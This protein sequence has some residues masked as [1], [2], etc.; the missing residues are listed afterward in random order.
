MSSAGIGS[1]L[2]VNGIIAKLMSIERQPI[3]QIDNKTTAVQ[4]ELT[5]YGTLKGSLSSFQ[6]AVQSLTSTSTY[7]ATKATV[8]DTAQFS[9]TS[10]STAAPGNYSV[11]VVK[12]AKAEKLQSAG[13][14]SSTASIGTGTL[15]FEFGTYSTS[16]A[17]TSFATNTDKKTVSVTIPTGSD[18]LNSIAEAIN[19]AKTGVS[20]TVLNDGTHSYLS[21]SPLDPGAANS[22][23]IT[24]SDDD[25]INS[26]STGLSKLAFDK[27]T[28]YLAGSV[29]F[30]APN[31]VTI[32]ATNNKFDLALDGGTA[33]TVTIPSGNYDAVNIVSVAQTAVDTALGAGKATVSLNGSNQLVVA[34]N[35]VPSTS[36]SAV[37]GNTGYA[38]LIGVDLS[39]PVT[40]TSSNNQ[41]KLA[42]DGGTPTTVTIPDGTYLNDAA[43]IS[44]V[45]TAV[46]TALGGAGKAT[47][48]LDGSNNL[49]IT[50]NTAAS[51]SISATTGNTGSTTLF[52]VSLAAPNAVTISSANNQ[53]MLAVDGGT[54]TAV[55]IPDGSYDA[56]NIVSAFQTAINTAV[57][58]G[59]ATVSLN[60]SNQLVINS[61]ATSGLASIALTEVSG[62]AGLSTL[63]GSS[64]LSGSGA[65]QMTE[66]VAPQDAELII[67][68]VTVKKSTNTLTDA[69]RGVTLILTKES[70]TA[71]TVTV[72]NDNSALSTA[73]DTLVKAY[74]TT[75]GMLKD[76]LSYDPTTGKA[77]ALQSEGAVRLIQSQLRTTLQ[78]LT[79]GTGLKGLSDIGVSFQRDGSLAFNSDKLKTA[80]SDPTKN[81]KALFI[82]ENSSTDGIANKLNNLLDSFLQGN[83]TLV[84]RTDGLNLEMVRYARRKSEL[85]IRMTA[86]ETRYRKQYSNL[87]TLVASMSK[88]SA[89]LSQQLANLPTVNSSK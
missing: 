32:N 1:G 28:G 29:G 18:S 86:I 24:V 45:Q 25:G 41:F 88:T 64:G 78:A 34:S 5:A 27:S 83:G 81:I 40:V 11:Q 80:L 74:N 21:F 36:V 57:G 2:D 8:A 48:S 50:S 42:L 13:F 30:A 59:K 70:T 69:I 65:T 19:A 54:P 38:D 56:A 58:A 84:A 15:T 67:D 10:D 51:A 87:D 9:V 20:A 26:D 63:F 66:S 62:D 44:L 4:A 61:A 23:R 79:G 55:T 17:V 68:G 77:G 75:S 60:A 53:F 73:V 35:T 22:L 14:T 16:G 71:T 6:T 49:V 3:T 82:G 47:V 37:I 12:L 72:T 46:D 43:S 39:T 31:A 89:Y 33:T 76:L 52:G 85:E 7:S